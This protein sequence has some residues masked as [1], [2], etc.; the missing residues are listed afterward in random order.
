MD[1]KNERGLSLVE[2][3]ITVAILGLIIGVIGKFFRDSRSN[4]TDVENRTDLAAISQSVDGNLHTSVSQCQRLLCNL[5][6]AGDGPSDNFAYFYQYVSAGVS[7]SNAVKGGAPLPVAWSV[8]PLAE[9]AYEITPTASAA[10]NKFGNCL[11]FIAAL[12]P[13]VLQ[14]VSDN[15]AI[16]PSITATPAPGI[17]CT[18]VSLDRYQ[19]VYIYLAQDNSRKVLGTGP[20]LRLVEWRSKPYVDYQELVNMG[21]GLHLTLTVGALVD[22][23]YD[24]AFDTNP[25]NAGTNDQDADSCFH[26][27]SKGAGTFGGGTL[28][29]SPTPIAVIPEQSWAYVEEYINDQD[30]NPDPLKPKHRV[31]RITYSG[32][33]SAYPSNY[34]VAYNTYNSS[35]GIHSPIMIPQILGGISGIIQVPLMAL[36]SATT[37]FP[38][39]FEVGVAGFVNKREVWMRTAFIASSGANEGNNREFKFTGA[40]GL[41][42]M[43]IKNPE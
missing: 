6:D 7:A 28:A 15:A 42:D 25:G 34:S 18:T 2:M 16:L 3:M 21:A 26:Q 13:V 43:A 41:V 20:V 19:F 8:E 39:G 1:S 22:K 17:P 4:M 31:S 14:N 9:N 37:N 32:G 27:L 23:G 29:A 24:Y 10:A 35:N 12:P 33:I 40:E 30:P 11:M 38:G 36:P 5:T